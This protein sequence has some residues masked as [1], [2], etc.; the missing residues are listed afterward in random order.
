MFTVML[1]VKVLFQAPYAPSAS[2]IDLE[3]LKDTDRYKEKNSAITE[4]AMKKFLGHLWHLSEELLA[5]TYFHDIHDSND[6]KHQMVAALDKTGINI[7]KRE[8]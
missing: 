6:T 1:Y 5:Y 2:R 4:V 3:L 8:H 7:L